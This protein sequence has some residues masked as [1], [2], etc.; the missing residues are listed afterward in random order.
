MDFIDSLPRVHGKSVI[1][2]VVDRFSKHAH[3]IAL[4]HPYTAL[5]VAKAFF[6]A[7][8]RLHGFPASI[9]SDRDPVFTGHVWRDLFKLAGVQL[10][11]STAFHPQ[12]DGQSEIVNKTIAMYLCCITGDRPRKWLDCL[13]WAEYCYNT[14]YHSSLQ[15]TPFEVVYGRPPPALVPYSAGSAATEAVDVLLRDRDTFLA[16]VR[17]RLLQA[18]AYA[19]RHYDA[20]HRLLEFAVDDWV[21]LCLLHQ[22]AQSLVPGPRGKLSPRYAGPFQ[23]VER[24]GPVAYPLRLP[25]GARIHD[26]FHVGIL[27]PFRGTPPSSVPAL[28]PLRNGR[29]LHKPLR[30]VRSQ[31]R[32]GFGTFLFTGR[33]WTKLR[34]R[35]RP[36]TTSILASLTFSSRTSCLSREG[37]ML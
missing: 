13:P 2:T 28:P 27:K 30:V 9:V 34:Q 32:R 17:E 4:S 37:E 18:Q 33:T 14:S 36:S 1:L 19:K 23:V 15:T 21:W 3:F 29:L 5:T 35:G 11:M 25:E 8:V 31:L 26:V 16:D 10:C 22:P 24:I 20:H 7:I 12:T 6:D